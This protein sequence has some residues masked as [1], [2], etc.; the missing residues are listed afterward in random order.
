MDEAPT[1]VLEN[2]RIFDGVGPELADGHVLVADGLIEE[3]SAQPVKAA[4]AQRID[5]K[6][7]TLMP[8][9]IDAHWHV[10]SSALD[11]AKVDGQPVS[12]RSQHARIYLEDALNRGFTSIR[13]AGGCDA[14]MAL[15]VEY[16]LIKGPRIFFP[17]PAL[18]Q[19]GG[20]ADMRPRFSPLLDCPCGGYSGSLGKVADGPHAL[21]AAIREEMRKG[22][23]HVKIM[24]SGGVASPTDPLENMQYSDEEVRAAVDEASLHGTYVM[25]HSHPDKAI[26]RCAELGIRSIEHGTLIGKETAAIVAA[27]GA[28]V[29][30]TL[31]I[32][33]CLDEFGPGFGFPKVSLD[34]LAKIKGPAV[35]SLA[36]MQAAGVK[37][38]FGTDLLGDLHEH[39]S[40]EFRIRREVL[41]PVEILRSATS[42]NAEMMMRKDQLGV[43]KAGAVADLIVVDGDPLK[44]IGLLEGQG[45]R[46]SVIM[47]DGRLHRNRL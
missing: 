3:V 22:A 29:V 26:R 10:M 16:G 7:R 27:R 21:R 6:G 8:G 40:R 2:A 44:D 42:V 1:I 13:D 12:L 35:D 30:P 23:T 15:A 19:T 37:I 47:K 46:L 32:V 17:G 39:Q 20:H 43:V 4:G 38:G 18:S 33:F 5:L 28:Y 9:L 11:F 25:A 45:E 41:S 34:K 14:G 31:V 36:V 24:A